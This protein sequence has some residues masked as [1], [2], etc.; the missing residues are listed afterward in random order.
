[1]ATRKIEIFVADYPLCN[2]TVRLVQELTCSSCR[3]SIYHLQQG[4]T[5]PTYLAKAQQYGVQAVPALA[6]DG[7]MVLTGKPNREQLQAIG[8][9]QLLN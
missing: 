2:E 3:V 9:G 8:V 4:Q 5:H 6:I 7:K 1:M